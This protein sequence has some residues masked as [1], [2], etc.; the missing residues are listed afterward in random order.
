MTLPQTPFVLVKNG[1]DV[2]TQYASGAITTSSEVTGR[3]ARRVG[4]YRRDRQGWQPLDDGAANTP[5][6]NWVRTT[7]GTGITDT[8]SAGF[9]DRG[10]N[11]W[12]HSITWR[13]SANAGATWAVTVTRAVPAL[14]A[15]GTA[16]IGGD[17]TTGVCVTEEGA[18]WMSWPTTS[19][20]GTWELFVP[21]V[22]SFI[23]F[24]P[25]GVIL[26][27]GYQ[28]SA[29]SA[30]LDDDA[31]ARKM[32]SEESDAGYRATG[33]I[34]NWRTALLQL[35]LIGDPEYDSQIRLLRTLI[36]ARGAPLFYVWDWGTRPER[37]GLF[38]LD[39]TA[40]AWGK[41]TVYRSG[42][43]PLREHMHRTTY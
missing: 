27:Q 33:I 28:L 39:A 20:Y 34:Y 8:T 40:W 5:Q 4:A 26:G 43:I 18:L 3:E 37:G 25:S 24:L 10:H 38:T 16:P 31:G 29:F 9:I 19:A 13:G 36:F 35:S 7:L 1:F 32:A 30:V 23:P 42:V 12:G 17:P 41:R 11:L 14:N 22:A 15:D 2:I 21:Y 6:G